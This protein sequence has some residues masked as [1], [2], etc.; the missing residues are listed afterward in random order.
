MPLDLKDPVDLVRYA[1]G[2]LLQR[3]RQFPEL[4]AAVVP[5]FCGARVEQQLGL[6]HEAVADDADVR[7]VAQHLAQLP[8]KF[9]AVPLQLVDPL[10]QQGVEPLAQVGELHLL[11][12]VLLLR[13][14]QRLP[15]QRQLLPQGRDLLVQQRHLRPGGR[16]ELSLRLEFAPPGGHRRRQLVDSNAG[17]FNRLLGQQGA[18][19]LVR[20]AGAQPPRAVPQRTDLERLPVQGADQLPDLPFQL[21]PH[22]PQRLDVLLQGGQHRQLVADLLLV[23]LPGPRQGIHLPREIEAQ[24]EASAV[25]LGELADAGVEFPVLLLLEPKQARDLHQAGVEFGQLLVL[26]RQQ[27]TQEDLGQGEDHEDEDD[28][29][30]ERRERIHV[31]G[32]D[33]D[34]GPGPAAAGEHRLPTP[35]GPAARRAA[36]AAVPGPP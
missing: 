8:E 4:A 26:V 16:G 27:F 35:P 34:G 31:A 12:P 11:L 28:Q 10:R 20:Q 17:R 14:V 1:C 32:P 22:L 9:R 13:G 18:L 36:P 25:L 15:D 19:L 30:E 21:R 5:Q 23:G 7:V 3:R 6:E 24:F 29:H 33:V 2:D